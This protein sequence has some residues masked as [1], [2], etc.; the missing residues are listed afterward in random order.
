M[1]ELTTF[2]WPQVGGEIV[3]FDRI[4]SLQVTLQR[5]PIIS[6]IGGYPFEGEPVYFHDI[7]RGRPGGYHGR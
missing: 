7:T 4:P 5:T 2:F 1:L 3:R 6:P